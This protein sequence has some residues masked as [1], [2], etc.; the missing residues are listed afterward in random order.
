MPEQPSLPLP[1]DSSPADVDRAAR[2]AA[3]VA[4]HLAN[5]TLNER[6]TLL[7][8]L[9]DALGAHRD[10]IVPLADAESGLGTTRLEGELARTRVQLEAFAD[11]AERGA[12]LSAMIDRPDPAARPAPRPD[13]RRMLIPLGPVAVFSA[14][15]FPLAFSVLGGDTAS[16]LAAGCP[17]V[18]KAHGGHPRLSALIG[19][20]AKRVLPEGCIDVVF[21]TQAGRD[22]VGHPAIKAVGFTGSL[23][24]GRALFDLAN[25]RPDPIPFYGELG[26]VNPTVVSS[27]ALEA[28]AETILA[29]FV[30]SFTLGAGQFCTKPGLLF[31]PTGHGLED[32]LANAVAGVPAAR[33]L[34][35]W[36]VDG[37]TGSLGRLAGLPGARPVVKPRPT[38]DGRVAPALFAISAADFTAQPEAA[39]EC[40][41]PAAL[42]VEYADLGELRAALAAV[43]GSL[44]ATLHL[45]PAADAELAAELLTWATGNA[46]RVI[47]GGWPTGVAVT[48]AMQHG[49]PWP[50]AT[51]SLHTSVGA[52][53][54]RRF[55]RP[56]AF[57]DVPDAFLPPAL[58]DAN[59][60]G[61]PQQIDDPATD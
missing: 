1:T 48:G 53:A 24:G 14:S 6:A 10:E 13:L 40:F 16:A 54:I 29:G 36:I 25:A 7:R 56:V 51:S 15:N 42:I 21:G 20:I 5:T 22:L 44:T 11:V 52:T 39:E 18:V 57:Q 49:G 8:G 26:S 43:P 61:I 58:R 46:G 31:L 37:F 23:A 30:T 55:L 35:D 4:G 38:E 59:P 60:L 2:T 27:A 3:A 28:R 47:W 41:G 32:R 34:G 19:E 45:E 33:M 9:A 17:V 12:F 50:A